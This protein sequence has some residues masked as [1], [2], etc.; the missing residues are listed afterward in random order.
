MNAQWHA[1]RRTGIGG[2]DA[3]AILGL[4]KWRTPLDVYLEKRGEAPPAPENDAM[5]WGH[6]LE[7]AVRQAYAD[8]TGREVR[9]PTQMLRHP[10]HKWMIGNIDGVTDDQ[11]LFEAKT[12]RSPEGWGEPGTDHIPQPYLLQTQHYMAVTGLPVADVAVL[13]GG[14]DFRIYEVPADRELQ[15][16]LIE[17]EHEFWQRVL[18]RDPPKPV[19]VE[20]VVTL[21]GRASRAEQ[22]TASAEVEQAVDRLR[23]IKSQRALLDDEESRWKTIV[24]NALGVRDTLV[25][26][27]GRVLCTWKASAPA[28]RFDAKAFEAA[29]PAL[30]AQFLKAGDP[31]RRFLIK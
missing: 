3:A 5:R 29:N 27:A 2:S 14:A 6:Y 31:V 26:P 25:D 1:A 24:L 30:Y 23:E 19:T 10:Q 11:R 12:A 20:D 18:R 15:D 16:M 21:Y 22:V 4:S 28:K 7:P 13:I 8:E 9:V 17:A